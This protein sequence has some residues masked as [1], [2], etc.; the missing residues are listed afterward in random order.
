MILEHLPLEVVT[1]LE[2]IEKCG[3]S[4]CLVGGVVRDYFYWSTLGHDLDFEIR[5]S[6]DKNI[7]KEEWSVY[8]KKL[9]HLFDEK[10]IAYTQLPYLIYRVQLGAFCFEFSSPRIEN[11]IP[12]NLTHHHF[13][14]LIDPNLTYDLSFKRRDLTFNAIGIELNLALKSE[15][16]IDPFDG[17]NDLKNKLLKNINDDF[18]C[19]A[20]RFLRLVRF[21]IK[22]DRFKID[23]HLSENLYKFNLSSLSAYH[24]KEELFKSRPGFFLNIFNE[25]VILYKINLPIQ[26]HFLSGFRFNEHLKTEDELL[27]FVFLQKRNQAESVVSLF[28]MPHQKI[29][30]LAS[31]YDSL[32][33]IRSFLQIDFVKLLSCPLNEA[34]DHP[35]LKDLKNLEEK[36]QWRFV[37]QLESSPQTILVSWDDW[38]K[39]KVDLDEVNQIKKELRSYY[40]YYKTIKMKFAHD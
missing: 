1:F 2:E 19:D 35:I 26:F 32:Q 17:V 31:F 11:N 7:L 28:S 40:Q 18:F 12:D 29:K 22:F 16:I 39:V 8:L 30:S 33:N 38:E 5:A 15:K 14:A 23:S 24:F 13:E 4:L 3:F 37:L 6:R 36:K 9:H 20:V 34:L 25:F 27:A 21:K 10:K